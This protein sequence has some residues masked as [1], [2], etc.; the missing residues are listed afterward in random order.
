M[1]PF[2]R[3]ISFALLT[4][5]FVPCVMTAETSK[6]VDLRGRLTRGDRV[7]VEMT[8]G[9][10]INGTVGDRLNGGFYV[11]N[12]PARPTF[13]RYRDIRA[14]HDPENDAIVFNVALQSDTRWVKP[15]VTAAVIASVFLVVIHMVIPYT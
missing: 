5:F 10:R 8:N 2:T 15:V 13:V 3:A 12:P 11:E 7:A 6:P 1:R 14:L 9:R 4:T